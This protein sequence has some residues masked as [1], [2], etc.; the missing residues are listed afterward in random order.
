[1]VFYELVMTTK[2]TTRKCQRLYET[3]Q[4][5]CSNLHFFLN[6]AFKNL[7]ELVKTVSNQIVDKGGIVR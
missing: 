2:N 6:V 1:M 3:T 5:F 7:T 4:T